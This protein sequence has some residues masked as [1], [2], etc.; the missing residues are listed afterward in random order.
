MWLYPCV[1]KTIIL[2]VY[3][4]FLMPYTR[5]GFCEYHPGTTERGLAFASRK[6]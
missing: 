2:S 4:Y 5:E 3:S 1:E 6:Y